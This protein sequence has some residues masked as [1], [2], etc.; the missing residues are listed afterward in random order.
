MSMRPGRLSA[1]GCLLALTLALAASACSG[2]GEG[3]GAQVPRAPGEEAT[4][5]P[6]APAG[7][8]R[9]DD[10]DFGGYVPPDSKVI[11][12]SSGDAREGV[13][14][15]DRLDEEARRELEAALENMPDTEVFYIF[16]GG[17]VSY[18]GNLTIAAC[19]IGGQA[20]PNEGQ[21]QLG[22]RLLGVEFEDVDEVTYAGKTAK[23]FKT[24]WL[25]AFETFQVVLKAAECNLLV[26]LTLVPG[27]YEGFAPSFKEFI[28]LLEFNGGTGE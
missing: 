22:Y 5:T 10:G 24:Q 19:E 9:F 20:A 2:G 6:S 13:S 21:V 28:R 17:Q 23:V 12:L 11:Y 26:T 3:R 4:A 14:M 27:D 25:D 18:G 7:W 1:A 8:E 15:F 16:L